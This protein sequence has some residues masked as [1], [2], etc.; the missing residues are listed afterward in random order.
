[1]PAPGVPESTPPV[2]LTPEGSVPVRAMVGAGLPVAVTGN[3]PADPAVKVVLAAEV[4]AGDESTVR[5]KDWVA[6]LPTPLVAVMVI[7]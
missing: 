1:M 4:M 7:G 2:K 5:V 3:E 6:G